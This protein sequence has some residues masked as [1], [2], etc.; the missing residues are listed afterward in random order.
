MSIESRRAS[1]RSEIWNGRSI[2]TLAQLNEN[3]LREG[4]SR[5]GLQH[6]AAGNN[7]VGRMGAISHQRLRIRPCHGENNVNIW[8]E[9]T[10]VAC[11]INENFPHVIRVYD[12]NSVGAASFG[13]VRHNF[14]LGLKTRFRRACRAFVNA[15]RSE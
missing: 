14:P 12:A 1:I 2:I 10:Y 15:W 11:A 4:A 7:L 6:Q 13:F 3:A 5:I 8:P 9:A